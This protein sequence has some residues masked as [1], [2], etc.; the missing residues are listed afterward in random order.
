[1]RGRTSEPVARM[2]R[3]HFKLIAEALRR[4]GPDKDT[5]IESVA[6]ALTGTNPHFNRSK[7]IAACTDFTWDNV[8]RGR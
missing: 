5:C 7:F 8:R 2:T 4:A 1:M 3:V 6:D